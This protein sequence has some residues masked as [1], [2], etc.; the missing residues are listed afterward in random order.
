M[1]KEKLNFRNFIT[2]KPEFTLD[3]PLDNFF[4]KV[5]KELIAK[6]SIF[7]SNESSHQGTLYEYLGFPDNKSFVDYLLSIFKE[8]HILII[9]RQNDLIKDKNNL[10]PI[11][12]HDMKYMDQLTA[13]LII[14]GIDANLTPKLRIPLEVR[15]LKSFRNDDKT[16]II[17]DGHKP[18]FNLLKNILLF[19]YQIITYES[20]DLK[21]DNSKTKDQSEDNATTTSGNPEDYLRS[22]IIKGPLYT[23]LYLGFLQLHLAYPEDSE[24]IIK[25]NKIED[26]QDTYSLF[27]LYTFLTQ[28]IQLA[29]GKSFILDKLTTLPIRRE[30]N[31][32]I[33]LI[34]FVLG[35]RED[36][37]M[38]NEKLQRVN[39]IILSKP[40]SISNKVYLT[41]IFDQVYDGMT[42]VNRPILI[43][44]LNGI[45]TD[46]FYKNKK[47]VRDFLFKR[48][49]QILFNYPVQDHNIKELN[50]MFNVLIS[51]SKNVS[52]DLIIDLTTGFDE[53]GFYLNIWIYCLFLLRYQKVDPLIASHFKKENNS[54]Y[55]EVILSLLQTFI[56]VTNNY[57]ILEKINLNLLNFDHEEWEYKI[58][59][60][61]QLPYIRVK[62]Y[63]VNEKTSH[64]IIHKLT[65]T[66]ENQVETIS[67]LFKDMDLSIELYM[68]LLHLINNPEII[69]KTFLSIL[70]RWIQN[71]STNP[72]T[73]PKISNDSNMENNKDNLS[74]NLLIIIDLKI[75]QKM[76]E[77]FKTDLVTNKKDV[78]LMIIRLLDFINIEGTLGEDIKTQPM[79]S[80]EKDSDDEDE[81][82]EKS[83]EIKNTPSTALQIII[84]LLQLIIS[85]LSQNNGNR[86]EEYTT[87]LVEIERKLN[88]QNTNG[89]LK[90][91]L[92]IKE[93]IKGYVSQTQSSS[94][95]PINGSKQL[96]KDG[97]EDDDDDREL[98]NRA[99]INFE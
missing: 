41:K 40:K 30:T 35:V 31:G 93:K 34:D 58:D 81:E 67:Q 43:T 10:L 6:L 7:G 87:L 63:D 64:N 20:N 91:V 39:K 9:Q 59:L 95:S 22:I 33:S 61:T 74:K 24:N 96:K 29:E 98:L 90:S 16:L 49:Y 97:E 52:T 44:C 1:K 75:L 42:Y 46:F 48:I 72:S 11:S 13:L 56:I 5:D 78:L 18:D 86:N 92:D 25:L 47:I 77:D 23:N 17:P 68:K 19:L 3:T 71:T 27:S 89:Q 14:H 28:Y 99:L 37:P 54:P 50:D 94:T 4:A 53:R 51:L 66:A 12:L 65:K 88:K 73:I 21:K 26:S 80:D 15:R 55:Y 85:D 32:L 38:D 62:D 76:N 2:E 79:N 8:L 82:T 45:I 70:S 69:T 83:L 84:E 36:E 57:S 60:E